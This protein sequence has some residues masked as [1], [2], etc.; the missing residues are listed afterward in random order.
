MSAINQYDSSSDD[1]LPSGSGLT[2][3]FPNRVSSASIV[4]S[5]S[6]IPV[7]ATA[8]SAAAATAALHN[9]NNNNKRPAAAASKPTTKQAPPAK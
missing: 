9:S 2:F 5:T 1:D 6:Q 4:N 3:S 8:A 7:A